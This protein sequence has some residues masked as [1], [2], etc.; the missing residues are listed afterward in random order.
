M[1]PGVFAVSCR[2]TDHYRG[3]MRQLYTVKPCTAGQIP[4]SEDFQPDVYFYLA[5]E[6]EEWDY[7]PSRT[8]ELEKHNTTLL[9]RSGLNAHVK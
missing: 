3:G 4:K 2:T 7:A 5:A 1:T 6:E 8:W 9:D